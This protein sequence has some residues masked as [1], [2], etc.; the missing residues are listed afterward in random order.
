MYS[1]LVST[2]VAE[3]GERIR[4]FPRE[5]FLEYTSDSISVQLQSLSKEAMNCITSW[6]SLLIQEGRAEEKGF[7]GQVTVQGATAAEIKIAFN[8]LPVQPPILNDGL[9]KVR[10]DLDI[11]TF[12][13]SRNHWAVKE[14]DLLAVL[15][16]NGYQF[17]PSGALRFTQQPL[18]APSRGDLIRAR[19]VIAEWSHTQ[20]DD[21]LLEA[22]VNGLSVPRTS[23]RRDRANAIVEFVLSNPSI[24]TAD[25]H[26]FSVFIADRTLPVHKELDA[27]MN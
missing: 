1:L 26:L 18:P 2:K 5:R 4:E 11:G 14:R 9:W 25:N 24:I 17:E 7:I 21:L 16:R 19:N 20:I 22:G 13:F 23:S 6:P 27:P 12:E 3:E 10:D 8:P 15:S